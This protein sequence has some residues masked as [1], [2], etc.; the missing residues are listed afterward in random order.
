MMNIKVNGDK[1]SAVDQK[2][3]QR[4]VQKILDK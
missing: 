2:I 3:V 1:I 4:Q